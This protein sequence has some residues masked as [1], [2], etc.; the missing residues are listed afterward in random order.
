MIQF[1]DVDTP[2]VHLKRI[3][4]NMICQEG[5]EGQEQGRIQ[6]MAKIRYILILTLTLIRINPNIIIYT[7]LM[8]LLEIHN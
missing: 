6:Q 5:Q 8:I 3:K 1:K 4:G 7:T 2:T